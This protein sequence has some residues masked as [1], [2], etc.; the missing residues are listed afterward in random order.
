MSRMRKAEK[1][2]ANKEAA[3][4]KKVEQMVGR[5]RSWERRFGWVLSAGTEKKNVRADRKPS[6]DEGFMNCSQ[7]SL[8]RSL[9]TIQKHIS[10]KSP[11]RQFVSPTF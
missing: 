3:T 5:R 6:R 1:V 9:R 7:I 11:P 8:T 2:H 4:T 10:R